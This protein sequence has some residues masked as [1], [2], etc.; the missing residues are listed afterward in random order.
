MKQKKL[1][2]LLFIL[3]LSGAVGLIALP[4]PA[5]AATKIVQFKNP[6]CQ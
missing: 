5:L 1:F 2:V 4:Q 6:G 3:L